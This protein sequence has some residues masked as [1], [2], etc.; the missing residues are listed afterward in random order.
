M[1]EFLYLYRRP[2]APPGSP[3]QMQERMQRWGAWIKELEAKGH[4]VNLGHP[5]DTAG[6]RVVKDRKGSVSDGPYAETKDI[7]A[8]F[9]VI[10]AKDLEEAAA[11]AK[12]CP[13]FEQNGLVEVRPILKM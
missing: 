12:G 10:E 6:G 5:L 4:L 1:S 2:A 13:V 8:G 7:V 3:Q 11:L 9:S